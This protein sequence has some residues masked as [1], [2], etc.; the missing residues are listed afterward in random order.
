MHLTISS[1][2]PWEPSQNIYFVSDV[3]HIVKCIRNHLRKQT[4]GMAG[5]LRINFLHY[6][7]LYETEKTRHVRVVPKLTEAHVA[8]DNLRKMSV[9]LATQLFS[10]GT[11]DGIRVYRQA[12]V[13]GLEDSEGTETFTRLLNDVFD[14]LNIKL[15]SRGIKRQSKEIQA[16][17]LSYSSW[18]L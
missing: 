7:T 6:V 16:S 1:R 5:D 3:P 9:R 12:K 17:M 13:A 11:S 10:R 15:P 2:H 4:Y 18:S 8:P 14:A